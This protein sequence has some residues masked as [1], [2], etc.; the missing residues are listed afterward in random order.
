MKDVN[1]DMSMTIPSTEFTN[2]ATVEANG[3]YSSA[4]VKFK[5]CNS[6]DLAVT[7][8]TTTPIGYVNE[9]LIYIIKVV[10]NGPSKATGVIL[11]DIL[12]HNSICS[13]INLTQGT[14]KCFNKKITCY[15]G[16]LN[17]GANAIAIIIVIP[18]APCILTNGAFVKANEDDNN[19]SN[20]FSINNT[21]ICCKCPQLYESLYFILIILIFITI[22]NVVYC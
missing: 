13:S 7:K 1:F 9:K 16:D 20:N 2:T 8:T 3:Y 12:P 14:Y 15:L 10:N 17:C 6:A 5:V 21:K 22:P 18:T 11:T 4:E 19:Y